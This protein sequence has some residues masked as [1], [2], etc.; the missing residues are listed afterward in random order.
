MAMRCTSCGPPRFWNSATRASSTCPR[1]SSV[2]PG[3]TVSIVAMYFRSSRSFAFA[4]SSADEL[5]WNRKRMSRA[6]SGVSM[7]L[8]PER[9]G[10]ISARWFANA[11]DA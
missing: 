11:P 6:S 3:L 2:E 8:S 7:L 5:G 1:S 4:M 10:L 9:M